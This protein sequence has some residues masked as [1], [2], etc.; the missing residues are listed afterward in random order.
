MW[1]VSDYPPF[2]CKTGEHLTIDA[3]FCHPKTMKKSFFVLLAGILLACAVY[4]AL[5]VILPLPVGMKHIE[6]EVPKG[7][8][9][10]QVAEIFA[11]EHI[12]RDKNL[13]LLIGKATRIDRKVRAGFYSIYGSMNLIDLFKVLRKGQIIEYEV[14]VIEG[15]S[16][17]EIA[18]KLSEK[19][20]LREDEF[21]QLSSDETLLASLAIDA[22]TLEGYL[23]PETYKIPKGMDPQEIIGMMVNQM[24]HHFT[25]KLR[26]RAAEIGF[27]E[28]DVLTLASIIEKEAAT[29]EERPLISA[30]Y[31]NRL[32]KKIPLQADPTAVYGVKSSGEKITSD[33]LKR[34]TPYNTYTINGLPPGPISSPGA[35]SITAAL[36]PANVRYLYFVSNNDGTHQFS[37]TAEEHSA[38]VRA[39]RAKKQAEV[40]RVKTDDKTACIAEH[41]TP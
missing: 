7:A 37:V 23:Y 32:R 9:F 16:L 12:I 41:D 10:R 25:E 15:D 22:P 29:D 18:A 34:K 20:I 36:Y 8:S 39:Y 5:H 24:R 13:F 27:S 26:A 28:R 35:K 3:C 19:G 31:H 38:A 17:R 21:R 30:V 6:I 33:D 11:K 4:V 14:T 1:G 40:I 2:F